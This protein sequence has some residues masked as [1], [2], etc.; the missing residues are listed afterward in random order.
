MNRH[1][2]ITITLTRPLAPTVKDALASLRQAFPQA[3]AHPP[4]PLAA[5]VLHVAQEYFAAQH[6]KKSIRRALSAW[7]NQIDYLHAVT[8]SDAYCVHLDGSEA[9]PVTEMQRQKAQRRLDRKGSLLAAPTVTRRSVHNAR[10]AVSFTQAYE[11]SALPAKE[12]EADAGPRI[13][14]RQRPKIH[15]QLADT[16]NQPL[17]RPKLTLKKTP[18]E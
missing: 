18:S 10:P 7:C 14:V 12:A 13:S 9:G 2:P 8:R 1:T 15:R 17:Q 11:A 3:L 5:D 4:R 6:S 16:A